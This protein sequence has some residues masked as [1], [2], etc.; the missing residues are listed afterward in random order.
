MSDKKTYALRIVPRAAIAVG[1]D[2]E[3]DQMAEDAGWTLDA[4]S[5]LV[6]LDVTD[7]DHERELDRKE[8]AAGYDASS[9]LMDWARGR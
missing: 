2:D 4:P 9:F 6:L 8:F 7:P 5:D 1:W 3:N